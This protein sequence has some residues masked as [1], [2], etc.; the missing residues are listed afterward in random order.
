MFSYL[1][2]Y[3]FIQDLLTISVSIIATYYSLV[4]FKDETNK[5]N[6][7]WGILL[8]DFFLLIIK[9]M[10]FVLMG[11]ISITNIITVILNR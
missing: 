3:N 8:L 9:I 11:C 7:H 1:N 4:I 10:L 6:L 5:A 2:D